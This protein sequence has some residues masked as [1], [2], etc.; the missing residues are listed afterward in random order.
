MLRVLSNGF[1]A[2]DAIQVMLIGLL[3]LSVVFDCVEHQ[4]PLQL[5]DHDFGLN[6]TVLS[7]MTSF[8]SG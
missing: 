6:G 7:C 5:L 1:T 3:H 8:V 2:V 4:L